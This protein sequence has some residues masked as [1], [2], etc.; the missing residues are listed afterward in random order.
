MPAVKCNTLAQSYAFSG[1]TW[2]TT[3][4]TSSPTYAYKKGG[5]EYPHFTIIDTG[6]GTSNFRKFHITTIVENSEVKIKYFYSF[7]DDALTYDGL[8]CDRFPSSKVQAVNA[9]LGDLW[10]SNNDWHTTAVAFCNAIGATVVGNLE[11]AGPQGV[12]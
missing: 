8:I 3:D 7:N 6:K 5:N 1:S 9:H 2:S 12:E 4:A 11:T 10:D